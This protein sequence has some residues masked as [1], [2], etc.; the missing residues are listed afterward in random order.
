[1]EQSSSGLLQLPAFAAQ[2]SLSCFV[3]MLRRSRS[4]LTRRGRTLTRN[5]SKVASKHNAGVF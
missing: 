2:F 3:L 4:E 1:L 5:L